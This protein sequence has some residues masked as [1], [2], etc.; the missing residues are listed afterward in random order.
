ML[1]KTL[2]LTSA[3]S[4]HTT[5]RTQ[6]Q[7]SQKVSTAVSWKRITLP[8]HSNTT[9]IRILISS[10]SLIL[11]NEI[12]IT[13]NKNTVPSTPEQQPGS[14]YVK[15]CTASATNFTNRA[16]ITEE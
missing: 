8:S 3:T 5:Q 7:N 11:K 2:K 16:F 1:P 13:H 10:Y 15:L 4:L 14:L 6:W 12:Y 9:Y